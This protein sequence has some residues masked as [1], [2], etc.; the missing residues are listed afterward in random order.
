VNF[1]DAGNGKGGH[2]EKVSQAISSDVQAHFRELA[3][4]AKQLNQTSDAL[5]KY[6][7]EIEEAL[8][9]LNLGVSAWV[10]IDVYSQMDGMATL[11]EELGYDKIGKTWCIGIRSYRAPEWDDGW[12]DYE[13]WIFNEGPRELRIAATDHFPALIQK[14]NKEASEI[15]KRVGEKLPT[16]SK[17]ANDIKALIDEQRVQEKGKA[18]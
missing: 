17:V 3:R 13:R 6:V 4:T 9:T 16:A 12:L 7:A 8:K 15:A 18:K 1:Y 14:L 11:H 2:M 10:T 5:G